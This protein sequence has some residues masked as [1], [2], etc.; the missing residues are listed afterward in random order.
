MK[1]QTINIFIN[2]NRNS[3]NINTKLYDLLYNLK[4]DINSVAIEINKIVIPKSK[5][6]QTKLNIDDKVEVVH[7]I[8]GG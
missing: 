8:G 6:N 7:F 3:V 5:Y 4:I 2:G 1:N